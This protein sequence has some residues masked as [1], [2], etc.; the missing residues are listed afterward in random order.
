MSVQIN[1]LAQISKRLG[2]EKDGPAQ[3]F[4]TAECAKAM[5]KYVPYNNGTLARTVIENGR[6]TSNVTSNSITYAQKYASYVYHGTSKSGKQ[7]N[8]HKDNHPLAG[9]Y[10]DRRM[11][12][13]EQND[14]INSVEKFI[15]RK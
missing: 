4:M 7:L 6:P 3:A 2:L 13:A 15:R 1:S 11:L 12:S 9:P 14:I 5:D 10:W 8:Y